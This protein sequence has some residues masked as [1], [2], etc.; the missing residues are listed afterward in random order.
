MFKTT[1]ASAALGLAMVAA[2]A[3]A[4][5]NDDQT[6]Q[7]E[8]RDLNLATSQGQEALDRRID[9][10]AN[11]FC[12]A[13]TEQTGTRIPSSKAK[14]CVAQVRAAAHKQVAAL[15]EEQRLGG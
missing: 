15:I 14:A 9:A 4:G 6:L 1:I 8:Y 12:G 13:G 5:S 3:V 11:K 2:P 10:A 7:I